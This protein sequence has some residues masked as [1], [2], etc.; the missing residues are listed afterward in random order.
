MVFVENAFKHSTNTKQRD[1]VIKIDFGLVDGWMELVVKNNISS[2]LMPTSPMNNSSGIG[3][4]VTTK[5][6]ELLYHNKY[7]LK[8]S[9]KDGLYEINL[10]IKVK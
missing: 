9:R 2:D 10:K 6:L 4:S 5:R 8:T 1:V 3:L 7:T